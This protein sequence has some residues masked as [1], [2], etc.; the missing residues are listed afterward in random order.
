MNRAKLYTYLAPEPC[1]KCL[2]KILSGA[3]SLGRGPFGYRG[4]SFP[5]AILDLDC[6]INDS[7]MTVLGGEFAIYVD[8]RRQL[9]LPWQKPNRTVRCWN[10]SWTEN[11]GQ[12]RSKGANATDLLPFSRST[13]VALDHPGIVHQLANFFSRRKNQHRGDGNQ[14][15]QLSTPVHPCSRST[16][17]SAFRLMFTSHPCVKSSWNFAMPRTWTQCWNQSN[18]KAGL[19]MSQ[20]AVGERT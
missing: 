13:A 14:Q 18:C 10:I 8:D 5:K 1:Q 3:V 12:N 17:S 6:N 9:E 15:L 19:S 20:I 16:S 4:S 2:Q 7:R 11:H